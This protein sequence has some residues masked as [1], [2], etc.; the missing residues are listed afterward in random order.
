MHGALRALDR[1]IPLANGNIDALTYDKANN[2]WT[3]DYLMS[4]HG[5]MSVVPPKATKRTKT[6]EKMDAR[7][8]QG[9]NAAAEQILAARAAARTNGAA[10]EADARPQFTFTKTTAINAAA[11]HKVLGRHFDI[12]T[13]VDDVEAGRAAGRGLR[14]G[15]SVYL[16]SQLN[17]VVVNSITMPYRT[18]THDLDGETCA[19]EVHLD[20]G[21]LWDTRLERGETV[22]D[23]QLRCTTASTTT[24]PRTGLQG[25][26]AIFEFTCSHSGEI[27]THTLDYAPSGKWWGGKANKPVRSVLQ[28]LQLL[29]R[30]QREWRGIYGLR[31]DTESFFHLKDHFL[32]DRR[33]PSLDPNHQFLDVLYFAIITNAHARH[34]AL[35]A[36][37]L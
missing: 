26:N 11:A 21:A 16:C 24:S 22:K 36:G 18:I 37:A 1:I 23:Q 6:E 9:A 10:D 15:T 25:L 30:C 5:V 4:H 8:A 12:N 7:V 32:A 34:R 28:H 13:L 27:L 19:H 29:P 20:D 31:N 14:L 2:G 17:L 3:T 33:T 35:L